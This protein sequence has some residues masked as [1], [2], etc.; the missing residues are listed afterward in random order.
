M[1]RDSPKLGVWCSQI[2]NWQ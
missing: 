2:S 1:G